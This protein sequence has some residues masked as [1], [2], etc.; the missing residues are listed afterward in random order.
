MTYNRYHSYNRMN[1][2]LIRTQA[3]EV[4]DFQWV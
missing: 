3:N 2:N 1:L 4:R